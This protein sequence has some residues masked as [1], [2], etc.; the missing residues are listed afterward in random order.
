[1]KITDMIVTPISMADAPL[2]NSTGIHE[3]YIGRIIVELVSEDGLSG[4][5]ECSFST[6]MLADLEQVRNGIIGKDALQ[7][8]ALWNVIESSL[9]P[10]G[11]DSLDSVLQNFD[12]TPRRKTTALERT[13]SPIEVAALDLAGKSLG[14]PVCDLLGGRVRD[15]VPFSAYLFYK[16]AGGGGEGDDAREDVY[17]EAMTAEAVVAQARQMIDEY[18]FPSI[19]LKGGVLPPDDE[20][21]AI[22]QLRAAF[23]AD[24]PLRIDPNC[25]WTVD[26]SL[27]V[28]KALAS[29]LEYFEDPTPGLDGMAAVR[30]GLLDAGIEMPLATNMAVTSYA[31]IPE[32]VQKDAVQVILGDHHYWG[33]LRA[34]VELGRLCKTF[35]LGLSMHSNSHLGISL[36]AMTHVAAVTSTLT[37]DVDTHYPWLHAEDEVIEG[38]KLSFTN[39][40]MLVP[41]TP[42]LGVALDRDALAR[43]NE[44]FE[45]VPYRD[46]DDVGYMQRN[47]DP[48][49]EKNLPLW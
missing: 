25:A 7:V 26:T 49:W 34:I 28:G 16:H 15:A 22:H 41:S 13:F 10:E 40:T 17:G 19:K 39:G 38:G 18:G 8:S 31:E 30:K 46:R 29:E 2:R 20:I 12:L 4:L 6:Q 43:G 44:R 42:G 37:Y 45:R 47:V 23:G 1:M 9:H 35:G 21:E 32:S 48:T 3:P 36:M 24:V 27:L 33:G 14:V 11:G 5:G